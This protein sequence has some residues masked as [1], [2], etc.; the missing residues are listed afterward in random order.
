MILISILYAIPV[1]YALIGA[2]PVRISQACLVWQNY[3]AVKIDM[4]YRL[5]TTPACDRQTDERTD[6]RIDTIAQAS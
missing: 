4:F 1:F 6:G 3:H 2:N 5:Y